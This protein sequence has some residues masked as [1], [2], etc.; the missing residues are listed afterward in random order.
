MLFALKSHRMRAFMSVCENRTKET[1]VAARVLPWIWSGFVT[2]CT[3]VTLCATGET[4]VRG[5]EPDKEVVRAAHRTALQSIRTFSAEVQNRQVQPPSNY[6][7]SA[8]YWRSADVVRIRV[9]TSSGGT[10]DFLLKNSELR[11][12]G[13]EK[14]PKGRRQQLA[15][16][17]V[18]PTMTG[19][20]DAWGQMLM[21]LYLPDGGQ[22]P[23]DQFLEHA[24][25]T[26][27]LSRERLGVHECA[28][29]RLGIKSPGRGE[30]QY[31]L[32]LDPGENHLIRKLEMRFPDRSRFEAEITEFVQAVPGISV[33][34]E[35]V[36]R[37]WNG[38]LYSE[39]VTRLSAVKVNQPLPTGTFVLPAI[40]TGTTLEN[41]ILGVK[42]PVD[43]QWRKIGPE[44]PL[45][46]LRIAASERDDG[47]AEFTSAS[48][49][50]PPPSTWWLLPTSAVLLA[51]AAV[52]GLLARRRAKAAT[53]S[54]DTPR[55]SP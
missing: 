23:L 39:E 9:K 5:A 43:D 33:P 52:L 48:T 22:V 50:E 37:T 29:F 26:P 15:R 18:G 13:S 16:L 20:C 11:A 35:C 53:R 41:E 49:R 8:S 28:C 4:A 14:D 47:G 7:P 34:T 31:T 46:K 32:W 3:L 19:F 24:T 42:Y 21:D 54:Q 38:D 10:T 51:L 6:S 1:K 36:R 45:V 30:T 55:V 2:H 27:T 44:E 25:G 17:Q 12:V 40:P